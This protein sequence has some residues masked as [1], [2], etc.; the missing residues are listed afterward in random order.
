MHAT[1]RPDSPR[2]SYRAARTAR[3]L[4]VS[5]ASTEREQYVE[6]LTASGYCLLLATTADDAC[7]LASE[8]QPAAV[9]VTVK[10]SVCADGVPL[11]RRL[12]QD[13]HL[14]AVPIVIAE[15]HVANGMHLEHVG[16]ELYVAR[17]NAPADI[18]E[19]ITGLMR[20]KNLLA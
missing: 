11:M 19:L 12:K 4:L 20:K 13:A 3:I 9:I 2:L 5:E 16:C 18:A 15:V 6:A 1:A 14:A 7:R 8:L 17:P 10:L